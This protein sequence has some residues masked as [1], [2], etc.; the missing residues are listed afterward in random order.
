ML[1]CQPMSH[2]R[3]LA[4][5]PGRPPGPPGNLRRCPRPR[6]KL[7]LV[8]RP[9]FRL[10]HAHRAAGRGD[11]VGPGGRA[12]RNAVRARRRAGRGSA[13]AG[14]GCCCC[15]SA[16]GRCSRP[17]PRAVPAVLTRGLHLD[18][19]A[20]TADG[21]G[22]GKP[23]EDAL[24]DHEAVGHR[25]VR[26]AHP[27]VR[28]ARP[29]GCAGS[30]L[31]DS[32]GRG[33]F[34]AVVSAIAARLALTWPRGSG[35]LPAR[36]E[37]LGA[38]VAG[39]VPLRGAV[40]GDWSNGVISGGV[41]AVLRGTG[42]CWVV[43]AVVV[44][45]VVRR[46]SSAAL[47]RRFGGVTG[48]VF[49]G[50]AETAATAGAGGAFA[51]WVSAGALGLVAQFPA[52]LGGCPQPCSTGPGTLFNRTCA[53]LPVRASSVVNSASGGGSRRR[54]GSSGG[55]TRRGRPPCSP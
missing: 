53:T 1:R 43:A 25:A 37:G 12:G 34:A 17:W 52:P 4:R 33:A 51:G 36:P 18:G 41:R 40:A 32:W 44:A 29:G 45:C 10:R 19:L 23:A 26:G 35:C 47:W 16:R 8:R 7:F 54:S 5:P 42:S 22:S 31:R 49:G 20:D 21:L 6:R 14:S 39:V 46:A 48:D 27:C 2:V 3:T 9:P 38:A 13:A 55:R 15:S 24:R 11:P 28:A 50:L 30:A